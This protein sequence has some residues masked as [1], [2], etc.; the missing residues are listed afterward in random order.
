MKKKVLLVCCILVVLIGLG[1]FFL[2][3]DSDQIKFKKE[4]ESI[5]GIT[6][7]GYTYLDVSIPKNN[8]MKYATYDE[9][10]NLIKSGTGIIYFGFKEC[11]WCRTAVPV[12][13]ET[14]NE[15][16]ID[17]ILYFNAYDIRDIK[18][19]DKD[20]NIVTD[21][22]GT[23]E[24]YKLIDML[25]SCLTSYSGL[26]DDSI[27]RLY[28]PTVV[29]VK[30]GQIKGCHISTVESQKDVN[31]PLT[32]I[33]KKELKGIYKGYIKQIYTGTCDIDSAC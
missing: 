18:H 19:L 31:V 26:N 24:Y 22:E 12:L 10:T 20:G 4:Y 25:D 7:N 5:N 14:A 3:E 15:N 8:L 28:F 16:N 17:E 13:I 23:K 11:P 21:K 27:K 30:N 32:N 2:K 33:Q 6:Q 1:F 9:V 29:F